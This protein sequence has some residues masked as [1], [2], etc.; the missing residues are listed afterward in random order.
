MSAIEMLITN[1][2]SL[3]EA[4]RATVL[5]SFKVTVPMLAQQKLVAAN[6]AVRENLAAVGIH[7]P[8]LGGAL[9][10]LFSVDE[11]EN[12]EVV[13]VLP[14][15]KPVSKKKGVPTA[16][17]DF[18]K[19]I[20]EEQK[21]AIAA[22][23]AANPEQKGAHLVFVSA[24]KKEHAAEFEA[25]KSAWE[26]KK[27]VLVD[28]PPPAATCAA[29]VAALC[30]YEDQ[31]AAGAEDLNVLTGQ[32]LRDIYHAFQG[33]PAG[34]PH[35]QPHARAS[36][37]GLLIKAILEQ[38]A[39]TWQAAAARAPLSDEQKAKM[40]AGRELALAAKAAKKAEAAGGGALSASSPK[41]KDD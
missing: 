29:S 20:C 34:L 35:S 32:Q 36:T 27:P 9:D 17:G 4:D 11:S 33:K 21:D 41:E 1:L 26:A 16:H 8:A 13:E 7:P 3:N 40:K 10:S 24:Y 25:F 6:E 2:R 39:G 37:K 23:K 38:R 22:F 31:K 18:L 28:V 30:D 12:D 15:A 19:K 14:A 5:D